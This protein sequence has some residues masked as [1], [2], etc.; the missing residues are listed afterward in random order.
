MSEKMSI[1]LAKKFLRCCADK[2]ID[3]QDAKIALLTACED[4]VVK[5]FDTVENSLNLA[6]FIAENSNTKEELI[7][8]IELLMAHEVFF[9][10]DYIEEQLPTILDIFNTDDPND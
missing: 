1:K 3:E 5:R 4:N 6:I 2:G 9:S 10:A 7:A 8:R